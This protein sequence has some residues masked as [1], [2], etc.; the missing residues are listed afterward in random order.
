MELSG[1][2]RYYGWPYFK[3]I[4]DY[5]LESCEQGVLQQVHDVHYGIEK[6]KLDVSWLALH[7]GISREIESLVKD[8]YL[9]NNIKR[10]MANRKSHLDINKLDQYRKKY[11]KG[12][13]RLGSMYKCE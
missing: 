9:A 2:I 1:W 8:F 10:Q 5:I 11:F 13:C 12:N 4:Q 6:C 3:M 7:P